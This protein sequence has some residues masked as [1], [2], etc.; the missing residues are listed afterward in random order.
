MS[1]KINAQNPFTLRVG[2]VLLSGRIEGCLQLH[3]FNLF[4][5]NR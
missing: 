4:F 3:M 2:R 5:P 1:A